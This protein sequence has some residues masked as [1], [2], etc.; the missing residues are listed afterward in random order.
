MINKIRK[1]ILNATYFITY[2]SKEHILIIK[3]YD[4]LKEDFDSLPHKTKLLVC[5][6]DS[7]IIGNIGIPFINKMSNQ[8]V[9]QHYFQATSSNCRSLLY[10]YQASGSQHVSLALG[11]SV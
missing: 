1:F 6:E 7:I 8:N 11:Y 9:F 5:F 2:E 10:D 4:L 3:L